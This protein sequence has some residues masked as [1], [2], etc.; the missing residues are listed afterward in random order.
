M[1][2]KSGHA[3]AQWW[4]GNCYARGLGI[5]LSNKEAL[6]WWK[7][8]AKQGNKDAIKYLSDYFGITNYD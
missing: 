1:A 8:A 5:D 2:A 3:Q 7:L 6:K 4:L